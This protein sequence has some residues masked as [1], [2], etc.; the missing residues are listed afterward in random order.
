MGEQAGQ[1]M[2]LDEYVGVLHRSHR[3]VNELATLRTQ[4][5]AL[6]AE[7]DEL[8]HRF[9]HYSATMEAERSAL[10][11]EAE[12]LRADAKAAKERE[13]GLRRA[14]EAVA[15][16]RKALAGEGGALVAAHGGTE[17]P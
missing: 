14:L 6:T 7:R 2:T 8:L 10:T 17:T 4:L 5:A 9:K 15:N 11:A 3:A 12:K 16:R 1:E 13:D